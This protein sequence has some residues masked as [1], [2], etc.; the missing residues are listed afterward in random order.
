M[1]NMSLL[2]EKHNISTLVLISHQDCK[3]YVNKYANAGYGEI[4]KY[5]QKDLQDAK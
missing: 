5:Q 4:L 3:Y 1:D 2:K